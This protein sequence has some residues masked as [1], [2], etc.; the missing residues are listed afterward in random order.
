MTEDLQR[1]IK[2]IE[3]RNYIDPKRFVSANYSYCISLLLTCKSIEFTVT[4]RLL[5]FRFYK[6]LGKIQNVL[7]VGTIIEGPSEFRSSRL[8]KKE[9]KQSITEE[10]L[11]DRGIKDYTKR[12]YLQIQDQK[13]NKRKAYKSKRPASLRKRSK[14]DD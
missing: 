3:L 1:D 8:T 14:K 11:A 9:R 2:M 13:S 4:L 12:A 7:H 6:S 5:F 10:L